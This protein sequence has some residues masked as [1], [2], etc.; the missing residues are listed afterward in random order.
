MSDHDDI[1]SA[2]PIN[3]DRDRHIERCTLAQAAGPDGTLACAECGRALWMHSTRHDTC[4][5]F[6][7][8]TYRSLTEAQI[9]A[10]RFVRTL[11]HDLKIACAKALNETGMH[12]PGIVGEARR[13]IAG[14]INNVYARTRREAERSK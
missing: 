4:G 3:L 9:Q 7:W 2:V 1:I 14:A 8:V 6:C 10:L 13:V 12:A 5:S 11:S